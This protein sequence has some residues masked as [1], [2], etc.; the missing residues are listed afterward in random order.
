MDDEIDDDNKNEIHSDKNNKE[1]LQYVITGYLSN[2][3]FMDVLTALN[4]LLSSKTHLA[5]HFVLDC[6]VETVFQGIMPNTTAGKVLTAR[7]SQFRTLQREM[8]KIVLYTTSANKANICFGSGMSLSS[9][10]TVNIYIS[11]ST[12]NFHVL[13]TS[14]SFFFCFK[15]MHLLSI[16]LNN[17]TNRLICEKGKK[18]S[19]ICK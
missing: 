7:K 12:T 13:N 18:I 10:N 6:Y 4:P 9:I 16:Y 8:P 17:I 11:I 19:I 3:F 14:T 2:K 1:S 5:K 15:D